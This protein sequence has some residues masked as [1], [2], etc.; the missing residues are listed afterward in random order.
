MNNN[1]YLKWLKNKTNLHENENDNSSNNDKVSTA[2]RMTI[3]TRI[4]SD[5]L[6]KLDPRYL[7]KNNPVMFTVEVGFVVVLAIALFPNISSEFV[8]ESQV[9][10]LESAIILIL[11]V[12]FA[13]FSESLSEAQAR[14]RVDAL[15]S[16][17][18]EVS[19]HKLLNGGGS[20]GSRKQVTVKST[21]LNPGDEVMV[22]AGEIIPRDGLVNEGKA[23]VDESMMTGE[24]NP[25]FKDKGDH[26]IGG[27][28]V[29]SDKI[30]VEITSE[31]GRSFLDQ[32]V[33]LI[34]NATRPKTKN[35]I[36]LTILLAG[37]SL[38]FITVIGTLL[39]FAYFLGY[40]VDIATLIALLVALMP[41]TIGGLLPA[42]GI[43][44]ITRLGRDNIVAKSGKGIEA[45]GDCDVL[46]LD[47]TGTI[48]E[49]SRSAIKFIPLKGY[50]EE[51]VGQAAF[52]SSIHDT[53]HEGKSIID[54]AEEKKYI[55]PLMDKII[56]AQRIDFSAETRFS[57]IEFIADKRK[58]ATL[59]KEQEEVLASFSTN[60]FLLDS[61]KKESTSNNKRTGNNFV[62]RMLLELEQNNRQ[63]KILKGAV[64]AMLKM[65]HAHV[66][67]A[68][69]KWKVQEISNNGE[70]PLAVSINQEVIGLVSLKDNLK[71][72]I[73]QKLDE[74][75][76]TGITTVMITGDNQLT[77]QVIAKE[78]N[79]DQVIAEAKP[80][81]KLKRVEEEQLKGHVIGMVGDGTN[82]APALA[83]ADI[84]LAMNSGTA[85]AKEAA[86]MVDLD[87]DPSNI[88]KVVKLG[89]QL[90]MTRGAITTFSIANDVAKYFA[91]LP[92][93]FMENNPKIQFLNIMQL[94]N[95]E[96][97]V[98]STLIFNAII[99]PVLIPLSLKGVKFKPEPPQKTFLRNMFIYG[100]GGAIL[101]FIAIKGI[102][103]LLSLF[104]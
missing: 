96:T 76:A 35:E 20:N 87:S 101:P 27:T 83:K 54:L 10:Y 18:K 69:L 57:G 88:L 12:W 39:F 38:I 43:S 32:M 47:K 13:T 85:A 53:S 93:M 104:V 22:Y 55:P 84:G 63:V 56:T 25:V 16:L 65:T 74:V 1:N 6:T 66:N 100:V 61:V 23:F 97:A 50:T 89:K 30:I 29:A 99:I 98:L 41:T 103:M 37:L 77:A 51:D 70:T 62:H 44:G 48:T 72:D 59:S 94:H 2:K 71:E 17:E 95:P 24:S 28:K 91:I 79:V 21:T 82:D 78:A 34:Q 8:N 102:D 60:D 86:N 75:R 67:E 26:V 14:A 36:A 9:F 45:A 19:A 40:R 5:S 42:I 15:R 52:A 90:L 64:D 68:E 49:G 11:T 31:A 46:I 80:T 4:L 3:N 7:A 33:G 58:T 92:A 73:R 81:D